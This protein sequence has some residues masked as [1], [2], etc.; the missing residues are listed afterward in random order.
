MPSFIFLHGLAVNTEENIQCPEEVMLPWVKRR[1][2]LET[3][4]L[5]LLSA[6]CHTRYNCQTNSGTTSTLTSSHLIPQTAAPQILMCWAELSKRPCKTED[7][8]NSSITAK[9]TNLNWV[10]NSYMRFRSHLEVVVED[11][12][13]LIEHIY[14]LVFQDTFM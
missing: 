10:Q 6:S 5:V 1:Q 3:L 2:P 9:F 12:G 14:S 7:E 4:C 11:N 13:D 8:L